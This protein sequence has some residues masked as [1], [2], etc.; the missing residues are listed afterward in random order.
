MASNT[1]GTIKL[2][3]AEDVGA[4]LKKKTGSADGYKPKEWADTINLL[5]LLPI[6]TASG[7]IAHFEDGA[8][9]VPMKSVV[10][11]I[12]PIQSGTGTPSPSNPRPISGTDE[13]TLTKTGANIYNPNSEIVPHSTYGFFNLCP[14]N[15]ELSIQLFDN[16]NTVS[17]SGIS[18]GFS[19][20]LTENGEQSEVNAGYNWIVR[21]G[22]DTGERTNIRVVTCDQFFF[23]PKTQETLDAINARYYINIVVGSTIPTTFEPYNAETY[24][25]DLGQEIMGGTADCVGGVGSITHIKKRL[26]HTDNWGTAQNAFY[27]DN[28]F[29]DM[30]SAFATSKQNPKCKCNIYIENDVVNYSG[31]VNDRDDYSFFNQLSPYQERL[32]V[33]DS[34]FSTLSDFLTYLENNEVYI[35]IP[36]ATPTDFTFEGQPMNSYLGTN[37][38]YTDSGE[39]L[40]VEYRADMNLLIS[41][42]GG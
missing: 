12:V 1:Y 3:T 28:F 10:A 26:L 27:L 29:T 8:D 20:G 40:D 42:L 15:T 41:E 33:K 4:V 14:N 9:D 22:T 23:S 7:T 39:V 36:L 35:C 21:S 34:T 25:F 2:S 13:L 24:T 11:N 16:D 31:N 30:T 5:G 19:K 38:L 37:N 18:F 17:L 32:W 6:R